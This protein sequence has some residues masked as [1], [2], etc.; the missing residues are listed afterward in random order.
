MLT[1]PKI[2]GR[3]IMIATGAMLV[4][5]LGSYV[6]TLFGFSF[7]EVMGDFMLFEVAVL[8]LL[9]GLIDFS[10]S[11]GAAHFGKALFGS[12]QEY[13]A[14]AHK[15][16]GRKALMLVLAGTFMFLILVAFAVVMLS[17]S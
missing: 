2:L 15:E 17:G 9:A 12:S 5:G 7:I 6:A 16:A 13:S 3:S 1:F 10:S 14:L 4:D 11:V 8:F